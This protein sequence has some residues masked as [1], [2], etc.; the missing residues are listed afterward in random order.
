VPFLT[1]AG[2][3]RAEAA[4][5]VGWLG[6]SAMVG[7]MLTG[8]VIDRFHAPYVC[9]G[10]FLVEAVAYASLGFL[11]VHAARFS[12]MVIGLSH[13]A[14]VDCFTYCTARYF[15]IK[16]YGIVFGLL[17]TGAA[18]G[19][20]IGPPLFGFVR[21]LTGSYRQPFLMDALFGV[22]AAVLL[23]LAGRYPFIVA[24]SEKP[25]K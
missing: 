16:S 24:A 11:P 3:G 10:V 19:N 6:V 14:E 12:I 22:G 13:G 18:I 9:A 15:G 25:A 8:F 23:F 5:V 2:L 20:G 7:R 17:S 1:S 4:N 21:D